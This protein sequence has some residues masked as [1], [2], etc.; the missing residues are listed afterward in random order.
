M[1]LKLFL[2]LVS[3]LIA[4]SIVVLFVAGDTRRGHGY[5]RRRPRRRP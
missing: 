4:F 5:T 3:V 2:Y 1:L